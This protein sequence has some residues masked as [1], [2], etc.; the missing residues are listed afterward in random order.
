[1]TTHLRGKPGS[2]DTEDGASYEGGKRLKCIHKP[3]EP[4]LHLGFRFLAFGTAEEL[5]WVKF[6]Y[7]RSFDAAVLGNQQKN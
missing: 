7:L 4:C 5:C 6:L 1:M 3:A 2:Q